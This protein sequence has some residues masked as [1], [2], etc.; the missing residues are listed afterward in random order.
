M[1]QLVLV[2]GPPA[3]GK[4]SVTRLLIR[5]LTGQG[6][7]AMPFCLDSVKE[8][9]LA[10]I[11]TGDREHDRMLGRA[12]YHAIFN[13]VAEMPDSVVAVIDAWH[14]FQPESVLR[15]HLARAGVTRVIEIWV[16]VAPADANRRYRDSAGHHHAGHPPA[17]A[18]ADALR[19]LTARA[20]PVA[21]GPVIEVDGNSP[22]GDEFVAQVLA[23]LRAEETG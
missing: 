3:S 6:V 19:D 20:R 8:G 22:A 23:A 11:G 21:L 14:G 12:G 13:L 10:E 18:A 5:A 4:S 16:A 15:D 7:A 17:S 1:K 2:N 9:L